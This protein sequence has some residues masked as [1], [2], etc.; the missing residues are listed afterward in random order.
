MRV[1]FLPSRS[2]VVTVPWTTC[3]AAVAGTG[4]L[5]PL[6]EMVGAG[7]GVEPMEDW[8]T[9]YSWRWMVLSPT[10]LTITRALAADGFRG[11]E[12]AARPSASSERGT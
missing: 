11:D 6:R 7:E 12:E 3:P 4:D 10:P 2:I 5:A 9:R 8:A 1:S